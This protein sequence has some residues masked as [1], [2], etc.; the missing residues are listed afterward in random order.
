MDET[1]KQTQICSYDIKCWQGYSG[2]NIH[3]YASQYDMY[4]RFK[5]NPIHVWPHTHENEILL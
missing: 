5:I 3:S 2:L 1:L 4:G